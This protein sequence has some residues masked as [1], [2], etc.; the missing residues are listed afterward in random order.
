MATSS[1]DFYCGD[2]FYAALAIFRSYRCGENS[3]KVV[4]K[5]ARIEKD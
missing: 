3:S 1:N 2:D 5:I 4:E